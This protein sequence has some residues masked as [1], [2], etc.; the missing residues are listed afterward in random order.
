[1]LI[2]SGA[3]GKLEDLC[4]SPCV[5]VRDQALLAIGFTVR[6]DP[7]IRDY[8]S[9]MNYIEGLQ[10]LLTKGAEGHLELT[11]LLRCVWVV[12]LFCGATMPRDHA[13]PTYSVEVLTGIC[14][15]LVSLFHLHD[16]ENLIANC[17]TGLSYILPVLP[18][19]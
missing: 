13:K 12:S 3:L 1:M 16:Q 19:D 18:G 7:D 8:L 10:R 2:S 5:E 15:N 14:S 17:M 4:E 11:S 6:H 9:A